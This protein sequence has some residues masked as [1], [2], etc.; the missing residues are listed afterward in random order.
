MSAASQQKRRDYRTAPQAGLLLDLALWPATG[1]SPGDALDAAALGEPLLRRD[2]SRSY[3][4]HVTDLSAS[5]MRLRLQSARLT[6]ATLGS[7][8]G[9]TFLVRLAL[10]NGDA[11]LSLLVLAKTR[12]ARPVDG[13]AELA[14]EFTAQGRFTRNTGKVNLFPLRG[15]GVDKLASWVGR[16][17]AAERDDA[18]PPPLPHAW[19]EDLA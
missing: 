11:P 3:S 2:A 7:F 8:S 9:R 12:R 16:T 5:G 10:E 17:A 15:R 4:L 18:A 6:P 1:S 14:F 13:G 19:Y